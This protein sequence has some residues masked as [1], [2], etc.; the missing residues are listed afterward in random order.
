MYKKRFTASKPQNSFHARKRNGR[1]NNRSAF[2]KYIDPAKFISKAVKVEKSTP[3]KPKHTFADFAVEESLKQNVIDKGYKLPTPIQDQAI[4][5]ILEGKDVV[6]IANTGTGKTAAFLIPLINKVLKNPYEKVLIMAPTRELA[7][8]IEEEFRGFTKGLKLG[9]VCT[10][11]GVPI[12]GQI[13]SL[14]N[15]PNFII[16]TPGRIKDLV[17]R[18]NIKLSHFRTLVMDEADR[19][20]DMGFVNDM[21]FIVKGM[22]DERHTL[23]FSATVSKEIEK[24]ILEFL[25]NPVHISVV[26]GDTSKNVDQDVIKIRSG[27]QKIE[28]LHDVLNKKDVSKTIIF[29]ATKHGVEKLSRELVSRGFKSES[30]HGDKSH[31]QR[32]RSLRRFKE[33][34]SNILV[35]TDVAARGLDIPEVSHVINYD[36]PQTY[37]DYV[38]RIGRT[39]RGENTGVALTFVGGGKSSDSPRRGGDARPPRKSFSRGRR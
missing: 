34:Q 20:L 36:I 13:R 2:G 12:R 14:K 33:D 32:Q 39:G 27:E 10:V 15:K 1:K 30:I 22:N 9:S 29:G 7:I 31:G 8:Q 19:M 23:F 18:N 25:N 37:E 5:H 6:G 35:A 3:K 11:G 28:L 21:R 16:G 26:T 24:L 17:E 38:H 4:P